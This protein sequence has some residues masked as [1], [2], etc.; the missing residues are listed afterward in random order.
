MKTEHKIVT[1]KL[2]IRGKNTFYIKYI[3]ILHVPT[4]YRAR[5][6]TSR[7]CLHFVLTPFSGEPFTSHQVRQTIHTW[8]YHVTQKHLL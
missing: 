5:P 4:C 7:P 3:D 1:K 6:E 2:N 8:Y